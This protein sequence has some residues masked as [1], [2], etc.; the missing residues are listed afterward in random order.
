[1][2]RDMAQCVTLARV[3]DNQRRFRVAAA[4]RLIYE[5]NLQVNS[6]AVENLLRKTSLVPNVVC[7]SN[8]VVFKF[9]TVL[10]W[11]SRMHSPTGYLLW[12]LIYLA[13]C[14]LI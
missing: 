7:N 13:C 4:R 10:T 9:N 2:A 8:N 14:F 6:A 12:V 5:K 3:D 1:M 11:Y